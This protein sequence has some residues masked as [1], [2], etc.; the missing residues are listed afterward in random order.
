[1]KKITTLFLVCFSAIVLSQV[2]S[3]GLIEHFT[4]NNTLINTTGTDTVNGTGAFAADKC[5]SASN[6]LSVVNPNTFPNAA[7]AGTPVGGSGR[8]VSLW[9]KSL[10]NNDHSL[11]NYGTSAACFGIAYLGSGEVLVFGGATSSGSIS[12]PLSYA[13][14]SAEWTHIVATYDGGVGTKL[15]INGVSA[16]SDAALFFATNINNPQSRIGHSPYSAGLSGLNF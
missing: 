8:T 14:A 15:Y 7:V 3:N 6:A 5:G 10:A 12:V 4:F 1:M 16:A 11:Y 9:F 13:V 2:P